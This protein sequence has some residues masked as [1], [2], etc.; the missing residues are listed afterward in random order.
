MAKIITSRDMAGKKIVTTDGEE[1]GKLI[2]ATFDPKTG[3]LEYIL[4][5]I[6]E[7]FALDNKNLIKYEENVAKVPFDAVLAIKD[8]VI[9]EKK[10]LVV[11]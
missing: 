7:S 2:D 8:Y 9:L 5:E 4:V 10:K 3:K 1:M 6:N 11:K